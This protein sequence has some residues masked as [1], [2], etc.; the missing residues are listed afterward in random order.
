MAPW[1]RGRGQPPDTPGCPG[2]PRRPA[3]RPLLHAS[4]PVPPS[5]AIAA[6]PAMTPT[7]PCLPFPSLPDPCPC[8]TTPPSP[9]APAHA[10]PV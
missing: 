2:C 6:A 7:L 5:R 3:A 10:A 8:P 1:P 9:A 4:I